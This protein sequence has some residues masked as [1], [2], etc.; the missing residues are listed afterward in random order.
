MRNGTWQLALLLGLGGCAGG[1]VGAPAGP[2]ITAR[3]DGRPVTSRSATKRPARSRRPAAPPNGA[4]GAK[5]TGTRCGAPPWPS[6]T[7]R[8]T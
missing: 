3:E 8:P 6:A 5:G 7:A 1:A 2:P 4:C